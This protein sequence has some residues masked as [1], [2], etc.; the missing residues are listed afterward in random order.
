MK[1]QHSI[2]ISLFLSI[3]LIGKIKNRPEH[4]NLFIIKETKKKK[5]KTMVKIVILCIIVGSK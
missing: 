2:D 5:K 1:G 4:F 3:K